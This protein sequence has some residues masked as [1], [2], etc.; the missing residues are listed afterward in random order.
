MRVLSLFVFTAVLAGIVAPALALAI[1]PVFTAK[2]VAINGH[3]PV[4]YFTA[5][6]PVPGNPAFEARWNGATWRFANAANRDAFMAAPERYTPQFGGY[7]A[8]AV[9]QGYIAT[10][11]P[12]AWTIV[13]DKL[14][15]NYSLGVRMRWSQDIPGNIRKGEQNWP[16]ILAGK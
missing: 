4:A 12:E 11:D 2:G 15:L 3:D 14:Y 6:K 9:S 10:T 8:W 7:C 1:E 13:G 16:R 5:S